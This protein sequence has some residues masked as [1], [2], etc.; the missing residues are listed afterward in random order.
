MPSGNNKQIND[1]CNDTT[2]ASKNFNDEC[3]DITKPRHFQND[4]STE[5]ITHQS[6]GNPVTVKE[7]ID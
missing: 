5:V 2:N 4:G 3:H 1:D 7:K 6:T